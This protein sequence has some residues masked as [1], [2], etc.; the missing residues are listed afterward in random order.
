MGSS[1]KSGHFNYIPECW[2]RAGRIKKSGGD[3]AE[4][5]AL[6][7]PINKAQ[8]ATFDQDLRAVGVPDDPI[9]NTEDILWTK[10][11]LIPIQTDGDT[12]AF[13]AVNGFESVLSALPVAISNETAYWRNQA[14][15]LD[16]IEG[17]L[18]VGDRC[19]NYI[20]MGRRLNGRDWYEGARFCARGLT[21]AI[22]ISEDYQEPQFVRDRLFKELAVKS[23]VMKF[24]NDSGLVCSVDV[25]AEE[26]FK[27]IEVH[28]AL[29]AAAAEW[30]KATRD[31]ALLEDRRVCQFALS[32]L[33]HFR[34]SDQNI[35]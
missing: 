35:I 29:K 19:S 5:I 32:L 18:T 8:L 11:S 30:G 31:Y 9:S 34:Q 24:H 26:P 13:R 12:S 14:R 33:V 4:S 10:A 7:R 2:F 15:K 25:S 1:T 17:E 6:S 21:Q 16:Q 3:L 27:S 22:M 20:A 23:T 28:A